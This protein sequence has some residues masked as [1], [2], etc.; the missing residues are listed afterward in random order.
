MNF[1]L[2][3]F[4]LIIEHQQSNHYIKS[5][6]IFHFKIPGININIKQAWTLN[7][8]ENWEKNLT[9]NRGWTWTREIEIWQVTLDRSNL[10]GQTW[11]VTLDRSHL[12][13]QTWQGKLDRS[14]LTGQTWQGTLDRSH[15]TGHTWQ[16]IIDIPLNRG[17]T[18]IWGENC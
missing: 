6:F 17:W 2:K 14:H 18:W 5:L 15:L 12:T 9:L 8:C 11:Q 3:T 4:G 13:G 16:V 1:I 7:G 10:T